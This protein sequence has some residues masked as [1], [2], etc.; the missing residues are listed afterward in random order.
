MTHHNFSAGRDGRWLVGHYRN[1]IEKGIKDGKPRDYTE[2]LHRKLARAIERF[3]DPENPNDPI[4]M[5]EKAAH[6]KS[7]SEAIDM[8]HDDCEHCEAARKAEVK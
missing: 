2:A 5:A 3:G 7:M 8:G 1:E 6:E 4:I